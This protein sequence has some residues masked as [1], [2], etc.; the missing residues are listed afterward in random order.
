[1][2]GIFDDDRSKTQTAHNWAVFTY[3][4]YLGYISDL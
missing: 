4:G 2:S 3:I 1:M